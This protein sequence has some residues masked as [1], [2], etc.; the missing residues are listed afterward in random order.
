MGALDN[1]EDVF[2]F[3]PGVD[4]VAE[5]DIVDED[6]RRRRKTTKRWDVPAPFQVRGKGMAGHEVYWD[7]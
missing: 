5:F 1:V 4:V 6:P 2:V 3:A 7:G